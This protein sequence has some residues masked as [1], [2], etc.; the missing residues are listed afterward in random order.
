M[1]LSTAQFFVCVCGG[2]G[3]GGGEQVGPSENGFAPPENSHD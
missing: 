2:G 1:V 3:G